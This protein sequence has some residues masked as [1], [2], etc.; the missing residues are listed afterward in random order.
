MLAESL[1]S[2]QLKAILAQFGEAAQPIERN[3]NEASMGRSLPSVAPAFVQRVCQF[4]DAGAVNSEA[5][6]PAD[7][8]KRF[9]RPHVKSLNR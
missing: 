5:T 2:W 9:Q 7:K 1:S 6:T 8:L 3:V 4:G